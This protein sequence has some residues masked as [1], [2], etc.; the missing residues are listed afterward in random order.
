MHVLR[1]SYTNKYRSLRTALLW[2][3]CFA[4][5]FKK[6]HR[7]LTCTEYSGRKTVCVQDIIFTLN[8]VCNIVLVQCTR[9]TNI[10]TSWDGHS[11]AS[12]LLI[13]A[14]GRERAQMAAARWRYSDC[15]P[16]YLGVQ[17]MFCVEAMCPSRR[18]FLRRCSPLKAIQRIRCMTTMLTMLG[19]MTAI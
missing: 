18:C 5:D 12:T 2:L 4:F 17:A 6:Q 13:T 14:S 11:M 3:V 9:D 16:W 15:I 8:R 1:G 7:K 19:T 10:V